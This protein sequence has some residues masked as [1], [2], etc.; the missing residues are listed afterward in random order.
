MVRKSRER[1]DRPQAMPNG[2]P[3][4]TIDSR[5]L[6]TYRCGS[7]IVQFYDGLRAKRVRREEQLNYVT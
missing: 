6:L 1:L 5:V 2:F 7:S 4:E 3:P